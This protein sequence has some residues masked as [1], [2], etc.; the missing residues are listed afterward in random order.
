M[1]LNEKDHLFAALHAEDVAA[2]VK[3]KSGVDLPSEYFNLEKPIKEGGDHE[4]KI[5]IGGV[6]AIINI[7]VGEEKEAE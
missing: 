2:I 5:V 3:E 1:K 7:K 4:I 6:A